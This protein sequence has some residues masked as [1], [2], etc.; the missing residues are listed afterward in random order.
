M[1]LG[2]LYFFI[3]VSN[4]GQTMFRGTVQE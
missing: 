2:S 4:A 1:L 3:V